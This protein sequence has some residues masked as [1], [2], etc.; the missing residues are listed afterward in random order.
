LETEVNLRVHPTLQ[1]LLLVS[2][3]AGRERAKDQRPVAAFPQ[4]LQLF[5]YHAGASAPSSVER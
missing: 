4:L 3:R 2:L 1:Q 5:V